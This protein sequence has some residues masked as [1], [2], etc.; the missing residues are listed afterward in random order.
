MD[1]SS[2]PYILTTDKDL[3]NGWLYYV[4]IADSTQV[5]PDGKFVTKDGIT[6]EKGDYIVIHSH[7]ENLS[8]VKVSDIKRSTIDIFDATDS[9]LIHR[10]EAVELST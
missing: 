10:A 8:C 6:L 7:D 9:D 5:G 3:N 2:H 1:T 4:D